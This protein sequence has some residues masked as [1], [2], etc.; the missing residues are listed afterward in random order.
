ME[1]RQLA[2]FA[3]VARHRHFT[4]AAAELHVAQ[5]ALSQQIKRLEGELGVPLLDRTSRRVTLTAAGEVLLDRAQRALA[6]VEA[7]REEL[8]RLRGLEEGRVTMGAMQSLGPIDLAGLIADFHARHPGVEVVLRE[9]TSARM[10]RSVAAD[11]LDLAFVTLRG[12]L[13]PR[14]AGD[15]VF[16]EEL[17]VIAAPSSPWARRRRVALTELA[18]ERF[19]FFAA[20]T[21]LRTA[22]ED[23]AA[24]AGISLHAAFETNELSR[25]RAL[26]ARGLGVSV[27]PSSTAHAPGPEV[28]ILSLRPALIREVG[29]VWRRERRLAP[30]PAAFLAF[31]RERFSAR[32]RRGGA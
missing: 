1:L 27:V 32:G 30:A 7:A 2:Y 29:L 28:A 20:G 26:A 17:V 22:V 3:A 18:G 25:V 4:R 13:D 11:E 10:V 15:P 14:L 5:P 8:A 9:S 24:E 21:G 19:V 23:A 6:E 12:D 31:A 16:Q